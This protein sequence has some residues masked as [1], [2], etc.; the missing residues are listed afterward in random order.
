MS[1]ESSPRIKVRSLAVA[2]LAAFLVLAAS[3]RGAAA[4][5]QYPGDTVIYGVS[6]GTIQPNVLVI[7]DNSGSMSGEIITGGPYTPS[8]TYAVTNG[9][10]GA[11]C[12]SNAVY[13]WKS[14]ENKWVSYI[15]NVSSV[16][17]TKARN[18]LN[19]SGMYQGKLNTGGA[20]SGKSGSFALGNYINWLTASGGYRTKMEVAQ[21]V[22][23]NLINTTSGVRFGLM[24]F[25]QS[26]G[27][28]IA[29]VGDS[30]GYDGYDAYVKDMDEVFSGSTTNRTALLNTINNVEPSTWTPASRNLRRRTTRSSPASLKPL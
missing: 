16:T 28:H 22:L 13:K 3:P 4:L 15:A 26:N 1:R 11:A 8:T 27:G 21:E 20:C 23:A 6:T 25:N 18:G 9:C 12:Q 19:N 14:G 7:L 17:C 5:D 30:Y 24:L 29:G 2:L 10:S